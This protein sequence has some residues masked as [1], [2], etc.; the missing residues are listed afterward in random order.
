MP[1][2]TKQRWYQEF[3]ERSNDHINSEQETITHA[4]TDRRA[5][6]SLNPFCKLVRKTTM[7]LRH[8]ADPQTDA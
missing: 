6:V 8:D 2:G 5:N 7:H 4:H 3:E 1:G